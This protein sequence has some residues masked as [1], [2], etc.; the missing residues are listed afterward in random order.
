MNIAETVFHTDGGPWVD[1]N[2]PCGI[3]STAHAV[4]NMHNGVFEPC[5]GCQRK[6][7][8][9]NKIPEWRLWFKS[10]R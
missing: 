8:R 6:G 9:V 2:M 10:W 7:W 3:C 1:H 5:W 4:Y